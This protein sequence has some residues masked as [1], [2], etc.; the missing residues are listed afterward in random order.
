M[1]QIGEVK[2]LK[3]LSFGLETVFYVFGMRTDQSRT[4]QHFYSI[5]LFLFPRF[6]T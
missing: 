2:V 1:I 4:F 5:I 6:G 3:L